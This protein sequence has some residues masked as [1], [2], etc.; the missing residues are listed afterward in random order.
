MMDITIVS[1][2]GRREQYRRVQ[3][4]TFVEDLRNNPD[5]ENLKQ[6]RD[7]FRSGAYELTA[8]YNGDKRGVFVKDVPCVCFASAMINRSGRKE[9]LAYNRLVLL[10][11][12]N[13]PDEDSARQLCEAAKAIPYTLLTFIGGE[14]LSAKIVCRA[15]A[16][17]RTLESELEAEVAE[18]GWASEKLQ[19]FHVNAYRQLYR[20][21]SAQLGSN[22]DKIEPRLDSVCLMSMDP[23][24]WYNPDATP[25]VTD[26]N[27]HEEWTL[28][29]LTS[30]D[31]TTPNSEYTFYDTCHEY[32]HQVQARAYAA[33]AHLDGT[34]AWT[35]AMLNQ[36]AAGCRKV[37]LPMEFCL[38]QVGYNPDLSDFKD[39]ARRVFDSLY[40]R[41]LTKGEGNGTSDDGSPNIGT[42]NGQEMGP[43]N[44]ARFLNEHYMLRINTMTG[45]TQFRLRNGYQ[46][47]FQDATPRAIAT[48]RQRAAQAG[49]GIWDKDV[50]RY[51]DSD[52]I[53][54]YDPVNDYLDN[55]PEWDGKDRL[56][57]FAQ[58]VKTD[59]PHWVEDFKV[60]MRSMVAHWK[61]KD[62]VH[63]NAIV[64]VLIG[65]QGGGKTSFASLIL[66][67]ELR[68]YYNDNIS[69]KND[70]DLNLG[71]TS[72][73]LINIDEFDALSP[74]KHPLLKY[75]LSKSDVK[76]RPPYGKAYV[77]RR[78]MASFIATTNNPRPLTD[79]SGSRRFICVKTDAIDFTSRVNYD[80]LYAQVK[81]EISQGKPYF[82]GDKDNLRI[83][84]ENEQ[85][86]RVSDFPT[87]IRT[88]FL[89]AKECVE[90][91]P[92]LVSDIVELIADRYTSLVVTNN[93]YKSVGRILKG[94]GYLPEHKTKG[95][96]YHILP[97]IQK[98]RQK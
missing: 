65:I 45:V 13:L 17:N 70:T 74:T 84:K 1:Y 76:M 42:L 4:E 61:G 27:I 81:E 50:K 51:L 63:G 21:Y 15:Q 97:I 6:L 32:Y 98:K 9:L 18:R 19:R 56:T 85:F 12:N 73:A 96:A 93:T 75:L 53:P 60:W 94:M 89:P 49:L 88:L 38:L 24:A 82:F 34:D 33:C 57:A 77:Q 52:L 69:F 80:Q 28:N 54:E 39:E 11:V 14:G 55:L 25:L 10:E 37:N 31:E 87:M 5:T 68:D 92:M 26:A 79:T 59:A 48:M 35:D 7:L 29:M 44:A 66:P 64:P 41:K 2:K 20:I 46:L 78:R 8:T 58:R 83:M 47:F 62:A 3:L 36:L 23:Q 91:K 71:L 30:A 43:V 95:N 16:C 67:P 22:I 72:F 90:A 40:A 86:M